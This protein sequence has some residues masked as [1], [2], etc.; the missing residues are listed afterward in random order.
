M[1]IITVIIILI[2]TIPCG[3]EISGLS[4]GQLKCSLALVGNHLGMASQ[5]EILAMV[6]PYNTLAYNENDAKKKNH[7]ALSIVQIS[8]NASPIKEPGWGQKV[9]LC[10][11]LFKHWSEW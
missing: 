10:F 8:R 1:I 7:T 3:L 4:H 5:K 2:I 6:Q 11:N 9:D